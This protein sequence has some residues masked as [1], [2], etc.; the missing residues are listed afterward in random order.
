MASSDPHQG[1]DLFDM[2][3]DG[4][5]I[6]NDAGKQN[7]IPSVPRP[8]QVNDPNDIGAPDL[9]RAA[10]NPNDVPRVRHSP[11]SIRSPRPISSQC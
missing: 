8:D 2:A 10:D 1:G 5:T 6:P 11:S 3:K 4:T 7:I 9:A